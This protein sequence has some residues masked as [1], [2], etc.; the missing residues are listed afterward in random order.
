MATG[1]ESLQKDD[2]C[3][4]L[5]KRHLTPEIL[6]ELKELRTS[7]K[8]TLFDCI[9]SGL[10]N[11]SSNVGVYAPD[12]ESYT[13]FSKLFDP[14]ID[15]YHGGFSPESTHPETNWGDP[16]ELGNLDPDNEFI[17]STRIRCA[18]SVADVPFN[19]CMSEEN[20]E[21][22]MAKVKEVTEELPGDFKGTFHPLLDMDRQLQNQLIEEHLLFKEGDKFLQDAGACRFWPVGRAIYINADKTFLV[23]CAEEDHLR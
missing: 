20:Y 4:S 10:A 2:E 8:S 12:A 3:K 5:L 6:E 11:H 19:P 13:L 15:D 17:R 16:A 23:W 7:F 1:F 22:I 14:I 21:D 9:K 18:R